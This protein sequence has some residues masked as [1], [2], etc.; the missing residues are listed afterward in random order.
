[1]KLWPKNTLKI[2]N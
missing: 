2:S 1:V